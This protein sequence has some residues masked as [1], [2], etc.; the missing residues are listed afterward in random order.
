MNDEK[1]TDDLKRLGKEVI[2]NI[3]VLD[4][5]ILDNAFDNQRSGTAILMR[6]A[7]PPA[8][9]ILVTVCFMSLNN[10]EPVKMNSVTTNNADEFKWEVSHE[11][12]AVR[13]KLSST[14]NS[15]RRTKY[16]RSNI[17]SKKI[18]VLKRKIRKLKQKQS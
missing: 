16:A 2:E 15:W 6:Y 3:P 12:A 5:K 11:L 13:A 8:V 9:A 7:I 17:A 1:L 14:K 18:N 10:V 4:Y